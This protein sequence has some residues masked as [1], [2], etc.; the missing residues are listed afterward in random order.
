MTKGKVKTM[1]DIREVIHRLREGHSD[2]RIGR[3]IKVDR[4][5]IKK[6]R[7]LSVLHQWLDTSSA[8]PPDAEIS[9]FWK[10]TPYNSK[11]PSSRSSPRS[12]RAMEEGRLFCRCNAS[13]A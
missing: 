3:E 13:T 11:V 8:I 6:I 7:A 5:I 4:S 1:V 10:S 2:R 9:K 12:S